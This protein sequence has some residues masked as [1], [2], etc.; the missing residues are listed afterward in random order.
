MLNLFLLFTI[1]F[2]R[3]L[4]ELDPESLMFEVEYVASLYFQH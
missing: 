1:T 2:F 3:L 4:F